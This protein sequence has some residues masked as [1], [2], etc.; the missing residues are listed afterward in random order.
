MCFV[1]CFLPSVAWAGEAL[2]FIVRY[3]RVIAC[4]CSTSVEC[5]CERLGRLVDKSG[6]FGDGYLMAGAG[7]F[8]EGCRG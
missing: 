6:D 2:Y 8:E 7:Q 1:H 5:E 3:W 4:K